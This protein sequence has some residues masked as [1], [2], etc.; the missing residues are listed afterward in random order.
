MAW[1]IGWLNPA[2]FLFTGSYQIYLN[3]IVKLQGRTE[4][5]FKL[6]CN[7]PAIVKVVGQILLKS[8]APCENTDT[9]FGVI[10][11]FVYKIPVCHGYWLKSLSFSFQN[12]VDLT[13]KTELPRTHICN[14]S[15]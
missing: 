9:K 14:G 2:A 8:S 3:F 15:F 1:K 5:R 10:F 7:R 11:K 13:S 4:D 12:K 6:I